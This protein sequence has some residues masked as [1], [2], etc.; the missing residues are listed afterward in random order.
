M[1]MESTDSFYLMIETGCWYWVVSRM[2]GDDGS[3]GGEEE[4][5]GTR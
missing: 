5:E 3:E 4:M 1:E 2:R